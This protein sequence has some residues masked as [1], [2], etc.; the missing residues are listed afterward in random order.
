M[1]LSGKQLLIIITYDEVS[2][3]LGKM[4]LTS[5]AQERVP[6]ADKDQLRTIAQEI[7]TT[8]QITAEPGSKH[9]H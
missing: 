1:H 7:G 3:K 4:P 8:D 5:L 6:S 9:T 2:D